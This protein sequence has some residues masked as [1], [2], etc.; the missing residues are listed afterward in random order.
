MQQKLFDDNLMCKSQKIHYN[1][2]IP[3]SPFWTIYI[4]LCDE[5]EIY[6]GITRQPVI[7][8]ILEHKKGKKRKDQF[9]QKIRK[10]NF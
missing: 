9:I 4:L 3:S 5:K 10:L 7:R 2:L 8:R 6:V 1:Y